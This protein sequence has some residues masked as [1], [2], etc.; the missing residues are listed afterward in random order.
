MIRYIIS[1]LFIYTVIKAKKRLSR[2]P[3]ESNQYNFKINKNYIEI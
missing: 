3:L 2:V 1:I